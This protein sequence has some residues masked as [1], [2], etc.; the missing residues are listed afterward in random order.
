MLIGWH[1]QIIPPRGWF[2]RSY[3]LEQL[4]C[5]VAR[6]VGQHVAGKKGIFNVD[7]VERKTMSAAAFQTLAEMLG[8]DAPI[9]EQFQWLS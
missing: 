2:A 6:P 7:L 3:E 9:G 4:E 1:G 8:K 5:A